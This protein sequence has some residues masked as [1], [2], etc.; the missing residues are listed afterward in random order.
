MEPQFP[1]ILKREMVILLQSMPFVNALLRTTMEV[2]LNEGKDVTKKYKDEDMLVVKEFWE[3]FH[4]LGK[5][6]SVGP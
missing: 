2:C 1:C 6:I 4:K 5:L 3:E